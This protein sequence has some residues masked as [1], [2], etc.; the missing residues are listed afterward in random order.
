MIAAMS[1]PKTPAVLVSI[2]VPYSTPRGYNDV[3][4]GLW[5]R[6]DEHAADAQVDR[7]R[8]CRRSGI[9]GTRADDLA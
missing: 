6:R 5:T 1:N 3:A 4:V 8:L 7:S 2:A 9:C